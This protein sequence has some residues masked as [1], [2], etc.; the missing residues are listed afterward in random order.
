MRRRPRCTLRSR[1][2]TCASAVR[3]RR[4]SAAV[5]RAGLGGRGGVRRRIRRG[6]A[7]GATVSATAAG[8]SKPPR[9][10]PK[11]RPLPATTVAASI[12]PSARARPDT[13]MAMSTVTSARPA[14]VAPATRYVV[15]ASTWIV[16]LEPSRCGDGDRVGRL[17]RHGPHRSVARDLDGQ[18]GQLVGA[19]GGTR[20]RAPPRRRSRRH[21]CPSAVPNR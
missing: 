6:E 20:P 3:L 10:R 9:P 2:I 17:G 16:R 1:G 14:V 18:G 5:P 4:R 13:P 21:G 19:G 11:P 7:I 12:E 8:P 15:S